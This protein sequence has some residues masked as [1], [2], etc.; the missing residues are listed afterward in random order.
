LPLCRSVM[1]EALVSRVSSFTS[2][3]SLPNGGQLGYRGSVINFVNELGTVAAQLPRAPRDTGIILYLARGTRKDGSAYRELVRVRRAAVEEHLRFFAKYHQLYI[4]GIENPNRTCE[5]DQFLV[6]PFTKAMIDKAAL[7]R[8]PVDGVPEG[9]PEKVRCLNPDHLRLLLHHLHDHWLSQ[10]LEAHEDCGADDLQAPGFQDDSDSD[11][12]DDDSDSDSDD[13]SDGTH[14]PRRRAAPQRPTEEREIR[15]HPVPENVFD[16]WLSQGV[17]RLA[18]AL[19]VNLSHLGIDR[20]ADDFVEQALQLLH[21]VTLKR[22]AT[23]L[24]SPSCVLRA[25]CTSCL[26]L[27][28]LL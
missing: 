22:H 14:A 27:E 16:Q 12:A 7:K 11:D 28:R 9:I 4:H 10:V 17:G 15:N 1:E 20:T 23:Q 5:A 18:E 13:S 2:V 21:D 26:A 3:L 19:R 25:V 8:L 6:E 24:S